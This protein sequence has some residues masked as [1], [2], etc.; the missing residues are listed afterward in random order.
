M[1]NEKNYIYGFLAFGAAALF[2]L[3]ALFS[4]PMVVVSPQKFTLLFTFAMIAILTGL[5]FLNGPQSYLKKLTI[6]KNRVKTGVLLGSMLFSLYFA[7]ISGSYLLSLF[8][9]FL[10]LNAVVLFFFNTFPFGWNTV[11]NV[12][13]GAK[14]LVASQIS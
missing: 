9:C 1:S 10:Q 6:K 5:G 11:K 3:M 13:S 14:N 7:L 12:A 8:F 4:L 2:L